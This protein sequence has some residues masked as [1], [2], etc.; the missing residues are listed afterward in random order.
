[1]GFGSS[2]SERVLRRKQ[3]TPLPQTILMRELRSWP[4]LTCFG[5]LALAAVLFLDARGLVQGLLP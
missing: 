5:M 3:E 4:F 1:M 2:E